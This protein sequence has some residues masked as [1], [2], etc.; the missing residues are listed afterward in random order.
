MSKVLFE[1]KVKLEGSFFKKYLV[2][3]EKK[4]EIKKKKSLFS[5]EYE[6]LDTYL[7]KDIKMTNSRI[8]VRV[9]DVKYVEVILNNK[10]LLMKFSSEELAHDFSN[11]LIELREKYNLFNRGIDKIKG[12]SVSNVKSILKVGC[13]L[14]GLASKF[15]KKEKTKEIMKKISSVGTVIIDAIPDS[16]NDVLDE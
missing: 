8:L 6:V 1:S 10:T 9:K 16:V 4:F 5:S 7:I 13:V 2:L 3:D 11:K 14:V 15:P 12:I